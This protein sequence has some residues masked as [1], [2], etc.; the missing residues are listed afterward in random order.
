MSAAAGNLDPAAV[1]L[2]FLAVVDTG[3]PPDLT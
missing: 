3:A 2:W 1:V